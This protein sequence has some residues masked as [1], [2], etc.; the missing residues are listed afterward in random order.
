M[1]NF[2]KTKP[3]TNLYL[4]S[5][6]ISGILLCNHT[7]ADIKTNVKSQPN[8]LIEKIKLAMDASYRMNNQRSENI[9]N[10]AINEW[11]EDPMPYLFK[12][13]L[14][15]NKF[16]YLNSDLEGEIDRLKKQILYL[17]NKVIDIANKRIADD[18]NDMGAYYCL[19]GANGNLGRYYILN[20][21]WWKGFW[22][23][24]KGFKIME[25]LAKKDQEYYDAYLGLGIYHYFSA[26]LPKVVKVISFFLGSPSGDKEKGI[27]ELKLV[28][29]NST[30]LSFEARKILL[31]AFRWEKDWSGFYNTSK[32]LSEHYPENLY[33]QISYVYGLTQN[34]QYN[35]A[36]HLLNKIDSL[37]Q[38]DPSQLPKNVRVKYY[39]YS[40]LLY[41]NI[42][43]YSKSVQSYLNA[44]D[45]S[46]T[47][48]PPE[49][50]WPEDY[51]YLAASN[52]KLKT[53][54][55]AFKY[56]RKAIEK[57]WQRDNLEKQP[58]WQLYRQKP[59]FI[60]IIRK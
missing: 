51:Y 42:G 5:F 7:N 56:L 29:D 4:L 11:P 39:R 9:F 31:R 57:G 8:Q 28:R 32:Y 38:N 25:K 59:E 47:K 10:D 20:G 52:A 17:N 22:K 16:R 23:G 6:L 2:D 30:L 18:P 37:L 12:G 27:R 36:Q 34:K 33:F 35:T 49:R 44:I 1:R 26:T 50:I 53:E 54:A 48:W 60:S 21:K 13:G 55:E 15:L 19:G 46:R 58:E 24:K 3:C 45:L 14:Y 43:K 41:Y 40:G